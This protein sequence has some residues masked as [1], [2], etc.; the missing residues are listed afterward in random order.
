M[1]SGS[2]GLS[3]C[4]SPMDVGL[5]LFPLPEFRQEMLSIHCW[6]LHTCSHTAHPSIKFRALSD[7]LPDL[8]S[9]NFTLFF[10]FC[11]S[12]VHLTVSL[13]PVLSFPT[14][15]SQWVSLQGQSFSQPLDGLREQLS[16]FPL[17]GLVRFWCP[18]LF[19]QP[20]GSL[21]STWFVCDRVNEQPSAKIAMPW[22]SER[23]KE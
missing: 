17:G 13:S 20:P 15:W 5:L 8:Y 7:K 4:L 2:Q 21:S 18:F 10:H 14:N 12:S 1:G 9:V 3:P 11:S 16:P 6:Q 22:T 23:Q 19:L